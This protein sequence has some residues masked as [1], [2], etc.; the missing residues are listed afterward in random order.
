MNVNFF[1]LF[2]FFADILANSN[3]D[4]EEI[5]KSLNQDGSHLWKVRSVSKWFRR[6]FMLDMNELAVK[7]EPSR[8]KASC[9]QKQKKNSK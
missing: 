4:I 7:Y 9:F 5:L 2:L 3:K 6:K 1:V 8:S